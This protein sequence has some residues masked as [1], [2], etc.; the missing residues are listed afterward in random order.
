[1]SRHA[2][3]RTASTHAEV[4]AAALVPDNTA[5]MAT[6]VDG[7]TIETTITRETTGGLRTTV[8]D[9]VVNLS[10]AERVAG[11]AEQRTTD[12]RT[13]HEADRTA[14]NRVTDQPRTANDADDTQTTDDTNP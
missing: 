1:M 11:A 9:Y 14:A 8:D 5:E 12:R 10:V 13:D 3:L 2:R 7:E 6:T 4:V